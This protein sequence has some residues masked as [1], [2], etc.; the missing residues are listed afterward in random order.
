[1][2][3]LIENNLKWEDVPCGWA[4]CFNDG[5]PLR[6]TCLR[7]QAAQLAPDTLTATRC[8][9]PLALKDQEHHC[10]A[11]M[12][13]V[14]YAW[15]F[16][17]IYDDVRK[18]DYTSMRV[19]MTGMLSGNRYYYEY[20]RGERVLLPAQQ[21]RIRQLFARCGYPDSVHFDRYEDGLYFPPL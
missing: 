17:H 3:N 10:F 11:S 1:M 2:E 14:R 19:Q 21:E 15:G 5:C 8:V 6:Q 13:P 18:N 9:T 4:L 7:W 16:K 20:M 12:E